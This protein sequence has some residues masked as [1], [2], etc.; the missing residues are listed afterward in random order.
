M[1]IEEVLKEIHYT[2]GVRGSFVIGRDGSVKG[3]YLSPDQSEKET[4]AT[5]T[6]MAKEIEESAGKLESG[7]AMVTYLFGKNGNLFFVASESLILAILTERHAN[8]GIIRH[9]LRDG[10]KRLLRGEE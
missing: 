10:F 1:S 4:A 5:I 6:S 9:T 7:K 3:A 2:P 8:L